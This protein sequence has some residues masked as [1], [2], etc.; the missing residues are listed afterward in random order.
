MATNG[1]PRADK[2]AAVASV[3][4]RLTASSATI[5][6]EYRGLTVAELARLRRQ[7]RPIKAEYTVVKNTLTRIAARDAG[8]EVPDE[9]L[10]GPTAVLFAGDDP[11]AAAKVLRTFT[12]ENPELVVK[13][14][15]LDGRFLGAEDT[16][17]LADLESREEL[18]SRLAGLFEAVVAQPARL[19]LASLSQAARLFQALADKKAAEA[20]GDAAPAEAAAADAP[21]ES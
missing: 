2:A 17:R 10:T 20:P 3:R 19:A 16:L 5:L 9:T 13:G 4:E 11:V 14:S 21:A 15:I 8:L 7:L 6:T 1:S 18:L 12:R